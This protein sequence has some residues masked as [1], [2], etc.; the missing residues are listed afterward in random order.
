MRRTKSRH[1]SYRK[2]RDDCTRPLVTTAPV[3]ENSAFRA[4]STRRLYPQW[5]AGAY[6]TAS[7]KTALVFAEIQDVFLRPSTSAAPASGSRGKC[8]R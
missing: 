7:K 5:S 4:T 8:A 1:V 2:M 6:T 3:G